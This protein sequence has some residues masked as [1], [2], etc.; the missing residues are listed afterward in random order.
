MSAARHVL[1][2]DDF[3]AHPKESEPAPGQRPHAE[4]GYA[5][6][7][8][9]QPTEAESRLA[10]PQILRDLHLPEDPA[11]LQRLPERMAKLVRE[12]RA[13]KLPEM[14]LRNLMTAWNAGITVVMGT[15]AGNIGTVHGP[16]V[17]RE[18]VLMQRAGLTPLQVLQS[19]TVNAA[20][21]I[22][23]DIGVIAPGKR[24]DLVV[25]DADPLRDV[26][27]LSHASLVFKKRRAFHP[28]ELTATVR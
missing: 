25:L 5:R 23:S 9:W 14:Q 15:D 28:A 13:P 3:A 24:A 16:G 18:M 11:T 10:D 19:A 2:P 27:N 21:V 26:E 6:S 22:G 12:H 17:L 8:T 1:V 7:N 4:N 20:E